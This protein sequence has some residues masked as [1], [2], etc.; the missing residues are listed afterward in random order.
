MGLVVV[1]LMMYND[2]NPITIFQYKT[3]SP[4][5]MGGGGGGRLVVSFGAKNGTQTLFGSRQGPLNARPRTTLVSL[6]T[7]GQII[8][9]RR[10]VTTD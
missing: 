8:I 7:T 4:G 5:W 9:R 10:Q 1:I 2:Q 3:I 6:M